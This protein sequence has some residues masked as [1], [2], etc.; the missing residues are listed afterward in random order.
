ML[1]PMEF[2]RPWWRDSGED[3]AAHGRF[4]A[5]PKPLPSESVAIA[6]TRLTLTCRI[7]GKRETVSSLVKIRL[8]LALLA[9]LLTGC[10]GTQTTSGQR[11]LGHPAITITLDTANPQL[12]KAAILL[13]MQN[14]GYVAQSVSNYSLAF[15]REIS[16]M[17]TLL[18]QVATARQYDGSPVPNLT[19]PTAHISFTLTQIGASVRVASF[20]SVATWTPDG[21]RQTA[22][23]SANSAWIN[24]LQRILSAVKNDVQQSH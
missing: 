13:E 23:M 12:V 9:G 24:A 14:R 10:V 16:D 7:D 4:A 17:S 5:P 20:C 11:S 1:P 2:E 3:G 21:Q 6:P 22:D 18:D 15:S 8:L 19:I